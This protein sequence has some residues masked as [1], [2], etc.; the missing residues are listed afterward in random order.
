MAKSTP[1]DADAN[2][3]R[4]LRVASRFSLRALADETGLDKTS[5]SEF[6]RS[7]R[8][9]SP[10]QVVKLALALG[11]QV[12]DLADITGPDRLTLRAEKKE[13]AIRLVQADGL[14]HG[15]AGLSIGRCDKTVRRWLHAAGIRGTRPSA[16]RS[17]LQTEMSYAHRQRHRRSRRTRSTVSAID[18]R[19][20]QFEDEVRT[21]N[22]F[23]GQPAT[24]HGAYWQRIQ[25]CRDA[26]S[27]LSRALL[28]NVRDTPSSE[29]RLRDAAYRIAVVESDKPGR[30][31]T[32]RSFELVRNDAV[33]G[34]D[35]DCHGVGERPLWDVS[36]TPSLGP[37]DERANK[38]GRRGAF[39]GRP[40]RLPT[41]VEERAFRDECKEVFRLVVTTPIAPP[42]EPR[43]RTV[44]T[45][46][47][48]E[49]PGVTT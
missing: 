31:V 18:D 25:E 40:L 5:I 27:L 14:S 12:E 28:F 33:L 6:D 41:P 11:G 48:A 1:L 8:L 36:E 32:V 21:T 23:L 26:H 17:R 20:Q 10:A 22:N 29:L 3:L 38:L 2:S 44:L 35:T 16:G 47:R 24:T 13:R 15:A 46:E 19:A 34:L 9:A 37:L 7:V 39:P 30:S 49:W 42:R 4:R 45:I 43:Q